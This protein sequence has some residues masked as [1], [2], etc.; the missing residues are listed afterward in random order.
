MQRI[1]ILKAAASEVF[2]E[3]RNLIGK[4]ES[5]ETFGRGAGGDLTSKIDLVAEKAVLDTI[6]R[7]DF[8]PTVIGE[9]CGTIHGEDGFLVMD[10]VDGTTNATRG[11]PFSCCSLAYATNHNLSSISDAVIIDLNTGD[12]YESST[13]RGASMNGI[14]LRISDNYILRSKNDLVVGINISGMS[15]ASTEKLAKIISQGLHLRHL[16]ANA[17]ELCFFTRGLIDMYIDLR[18]K[19]RVTDLAAG[20]LIT[21]EAG[22]MLF[23]PCGETLDSDLSLHNRISFIAAKSK[24]FF[25]LFQGS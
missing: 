24:E 25:Q 9:E 1:D 21:K 7:F 5:A 10:A 2:R 14:R 13:N 16:G 8:M 15:A 19:I 20:Y 18:G 6:E 4:P 3:T 12:L 22:G 23:D 11:I 17:L